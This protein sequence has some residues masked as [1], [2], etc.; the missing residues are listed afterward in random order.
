L[1]QNFEGNE[2]SRVSDAAVFERLF[3]SQADR[4][5]F[6]PSK[7]FLSYFILYFGLNEES[8]YNLEIFKMSYKI[9]NRKDIAVFTGNISNPNDFDTINYFKDKLKSYRNSIE[10]ID[11]QL[12]KNESINFKIKQSMDIVLKENSKEFANDRMKEN[13]IIKIMSWIK[14][15]IGSLT[16]DKIDSPKIIFYGEAKKHELLFFDVMFL[17]GFDVIYL[18]PNKKTDIGVLD[19][20][21][22]NNLE[23]IEERFSTENMTFEDRKE[24]GRKVEKGSVKK[25]YTVGAQASE[26]IGRELMEES[27]FIKPW[28][29]QD[30]IIK[31]L[32]LSTTVDEIS[33][34]WSEPAK[35]RPG[36]GFDNKLVQ[37][38][39]FLTKIDGIYR[40]SSKYIE[41]INKLKNSE[42]AYF[43]EYFGRP[44]VF[45]KEFTRADF[46]M[47]FLI[48]AAGKI[49]KKDILNNP[50]YQTS[51]L[52]INTQIMIL[53][54]VE[55]LFE[56]N[57]F[58]TGLDSEER[59]KGLHAVL[60]MDR[61]FVRMLNNFDYSGVTPKLVVFVGKDYI[62]PKETCFL[63]LLLSKVGFDVVVLTPGGENNIENMISGKLIDIH[64]LE[65]MEYD[66]H[67]NNLDKEVP[68]FKKL[69]GKM[70]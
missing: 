4:G 64:R 3:S 61:Q 52:S 16:I 56:G 25:A 45:S 10:S 43:I 41:F 69:F 9:D 24:L 50:E 14:E 58:T 29:L 2:G 1:G 33:I 42:Y 47:S 7:G 57:L 65:K 39:V 22:Q 23:V 19:V 40:D 67:M 31:N 54:K 48:S 13:F 53:D 20:K 46:G 44:G 59:I 66:L 30:R 12:V 36:F 32:L 68:L 34:Y 55:E 6:T 5:N 51:S 8:L 62:F 60:N 17:A 63:I 38:P 28:Q 37:M 15:Y 49:E 18:S 21:R 27:G 11:I 70:R 35:L 26:R